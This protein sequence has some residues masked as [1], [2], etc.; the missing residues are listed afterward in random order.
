[1]PLPKR[2]NQ[3]STPETMLEVTN[4]LRETEE[5]ARDILH[6]TSRGFGIDEYDMGAGAAESE[7]EALEELDAPGLQTDL[8]SPVDSQEGL[9][10]DESSELVQPASAEN[11]FNDDQLAHLSREDSFNEAEEGESRISHSIRDFQSQLETDH[12][13]E[14]NHSD[15]LNE[16]ARRREELARKE[17]ERRADRA[18]KEQQE[19]RKRQ[20]LSKDKT[21]RGRFGNITLEFALDAPYDGYKFL[22]PKIQDM[23][24]LIQK[25]LKD[26]GNSE[27]IGKARKDRGGEM[28]DKMQNLVDR[29]ITRELMRNEGN[30][31]VEKEY[32]SYFTA[33]VTNE[34]IGFGPLEPFWEDSSVSE[35]MVNGPYD[36]RVEIKGKTRIAHGVRF[37]DQEHLETA[38][39]SLL[40]LSGRQFSVK[41]P[42]A[43]AP[44]PDGSRL[45][46]THTTISPKGPYLT[47]RRFPDTIFSLKKMVDT[48]SMT[49]EMAVE[50]GNLVHHG[51]S[52]VVAGGTGTG[53]ALDDNTIIPTP[54]G[55]KRLKELH[56]GDQVFG[57]EGTPI[58][59][60]GVFPQPDGRACYDVKFSDGS[61]V[62]A[63]AEHNWSVNDG[64]VLTTAQILSRFKYETFNLPSHKGVKGAE[65][66]LSIHPYLLG[67]WIAC[68]TSDGLIANQ[69]VSIEGFLADAGYTFSKIIPP[70]SGGVSM[71]KVDK[72]IERL[73]SFDLLGDQVSIPQEY[74]FSSRSQ[75]SA[76]LAGLLCNG[77]IEHKAKSEVDYLVADNRVL[78]RQIVSLAGSLGLNPL[79]TEYESN[80]TEVF[81]IL[82]TTKGHNLLSLDCKSQ[83]THQFEGDD[84]SE[85]FS[86]QMV[87]IEPV[88]TRDVRCIT[89]D[90]EDH[91]YLFGEEFTVTHNTSMLNALSGC[92]SDDER[93]ITLEDTLELQLNP[94]KQVLSLQSKPASASGDGAITIRDLVRNSLRMHPDRIIVGETRDSSAYDMLQ[95]MSTGHD[96][97]LTTTHASNPQGTIERLASL[98]SEAGE[99]GSNE[100]ALGLIA[101]ALD[102]IVS[103]ERYEDGSRRVSSVSEIPRIQVEDGRVSLKPILLWEYVRDGYDPTDGKTVIGH[104]EKQNDISPTLRRDKS[105]D[106]KRKLTIEELYVLSFV[107]SPDDTANEDE[108]TLQES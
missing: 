81:S 22:E 25:T 82:F 11:L 102:I 60:V 94:N 24:D 48:G 49:E 67:Y 1:M 50:L 3:F 34:I 35:V 64:T 46:A 92:V 31:K 97:S 2:P 100:Q 30:I 65:K 69:N 29:Y 54:E 90:S 55:F 57:R 83:S 80:L 47:I 63:D 84:S 72:L 68:G 87:S 8:L 5:Y 71:L 103:I 39:K 76:L 86:K 91:L 79:Y 10:G 51:C 12:E 42:T 18:R 33:A 21:R 62:I 93:I 20:A 74:L 38:T 95:A 77:G 66:E 45:N 6:E 59:V 13:D 99:I 16:M 27:N 14:S 96:G 104:Y 89:V 4:E 40:A 98:A 107:E 17:E 44:L 53:K 108:S 78:A 56:V 41:N 58:N 61:S 32:A 19:E 9:Y 106:T 28:F 36:I 101:G 52:M 7:S 75:R 37:R 26:N 43:D 73:K 85:S 105:L 70:H 88:K 15:I 23:V